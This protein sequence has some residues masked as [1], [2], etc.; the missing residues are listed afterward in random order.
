MD[1]VEIS[2]HDKESLHLPMKNGTSVD[3]DHL[4]EFNNNL[5]DL[6]NLKGKVDDKDK[7]VLL[8]IYLPPVINT[9]ELCKMDRETLQEKV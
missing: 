6:E 2:L 7:I 4:D 5:T 3:Q 8:L 1:L 9:R